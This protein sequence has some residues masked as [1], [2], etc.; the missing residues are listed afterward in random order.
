MDKACVSAG[1]LEVD[2]D[3]QATLPGN[4]EAEPASLSQDIDHVPQQVGNVKSSPF[5]ASPAT[6]KSQ[7]R[8]ETS[9]FSE[10]DQDFEFSSTSISESA[11]VGVKTQ[12]MSKEGLSLTRDFSSGEQAE[13]S[14]GADG[15]HIQGKGATEGSVNDAPHSTV[16]VETVPLR[17]GSRYN[18]LPPQQPGAFRIPGVP[19]M[20]TPRGS[21]NR[22]VSP[23]EIDE[24][25]V[26]VEPPSNA[27][28]FDAVLVDGDPNSSTPPNGMIQVATEVHPLESASRGFRRLAICL[29]IVATVV[30]VA[31]VVGAVVSSSREQ[32]PAMSRNVTIKEF[33]DVLLP[34]RS[35][36]EATLDPL[37]PP[38]RALQWL[39]SDVR[40][41]EMLGWR[42]LQRF[43]LA[44]M[45][46]SLNGEHWFNQSGW[47]SSQ[48]ECSWFRGTQYICWMA[49]PVIQAANLSCLG[50]LRTTRRVRFPVS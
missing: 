11:C 49:T 15:M 28:V 8:P 1:D 3:R 14:L 30:V 16:P 38:G 48:N 12:L 47:I 19:P 13:I 35:L 10:N 37:S 46:F 5:T 50:C 26:D 27:L 32:L 44:V 2:E 6:F 29:L 36:E 43:S 25:P 40:G 22:I 21:A 24:L 42:L 18:W 33:R 23:L 20:R 39:E 17:R 45:Y 4:E 31:A 34:A 9:H 7:V 41:E